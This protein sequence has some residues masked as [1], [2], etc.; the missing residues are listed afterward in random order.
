VTRT[1]G[2]DAGGDKFEHTRHERRRRRIDDQPHA[3]GARHVLR[4][5]EQPEAGNIGCRVRA[6][7]EHRLGGAVVE[8]RHRSDRL[9]EFF[10][11]DRIALASRR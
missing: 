2:N 3:R 6:R 7:R 1:A 4:V 10:G 8:C 5:P 9:I 11:R